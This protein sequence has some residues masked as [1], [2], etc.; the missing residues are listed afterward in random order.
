MPQAT[1]ERSQIAGLGVE[2]V[3]GRWQNSDMG[4]LRRRW[5]V[6]KWAGVAGSALVLA[7]W[8]I[9][10]H[11]W[12]RYISSIGV[13]SAQVIPG[14][15]PSG[16]LLGLG[17]GGVYLCHGL[18]L[19]LSFPGGGSGWA[20]CRTPWSSWNSCVGWPRIVDLRSAPIGGW[21][22]MAVVPLWIPFLLIC[23]P[24][25][26]LCWR[27]RRVIS[28]WVRRRR[29]ARWIAQLAAA[30]TFLG[31]SWLIYLGLDSAAIAA[32]VTVDDASR[33]LGVPEGVALGTSI[34]AIFLASYVPSRLL[35]FLL[36]WRPI[37]VGDPVLDPA[38]SCQKCNYDLTGNLSGICPECGHAI[39][40]P[41]AKS[42][43]SVAKAAKSAVLAL[44]FIAVSGAIGF[45]LLSP[46]P[47]NKP[48]PP[49]FCRDHSGEPEI[50]FDLRGSALF[51]DRERNTIFLLPAFGD[52]RGSGIAVNPSLNDAEFGVAGVKWRVPAEDDS[53][54]IAGRHGEV[55]SYH[56]RD[57]F[58]NRVV[59]DIAKLSV[60]RAPDI[61][62]VLIKSC[63]WKD[64]EA[65]SA[66][67]AL[68]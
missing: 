38:L 43:Y 51:V 2:P 63:R 50:T 18:V 67:S 53:L 65:K 54:F 4:R 56:L 17:Q 3:T 15:A 13:P 47:R 23:A 64:A 29:P 1:I 68:R 40:Q 59:D 6:V 60:P 36:R 33:L 30:L 52:D 19:H 61:I 16:W 48:L 5:R 44:S 26:L 27:D 49:L 57:G 34:A 46:P 55:K 14:V 11:C 66:V 20:A 21:G 45:F 8:V 31:G 25:V 9:S 28:Q 42:R 32:G 37:Y 62:D 10:L 41:A 24:T 39:N 7:T 22:W 35:L 58:V 12:C